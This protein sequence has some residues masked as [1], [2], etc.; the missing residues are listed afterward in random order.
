MKTKPFIFSKFDN[1]IRVELTVLFIFIMLVSSLTISVLSYYT[2]KAELDRSGEII[3]KNGVKMVKEAIHLKVNAV[4]LGIQDIDTAQ[5]EIK[6]L[7][8]GPKNSDGTRPINRN[9][10][11]GENGYFF[12]L[13]KYADEIAHPSIEG[14][15]TWLT[16]D[17][18]GKDFYV[19]QD[20]IKKAQNGGGFT[21]YSW[22]WPYSDRIAPKV[23]Y[24]EID[25]NWD[26]IIVSSIYLEDYN[27]GAKRIFL[28][29]IYTIFAILVIG[30]ALLIWIDGHIASPIKKM[31]KA[32]KHFDINNLRFT[33]IDV[34][35]RNEIGLLATSFNQMAENLIAENA[36]LVNAE[37]KLMQL[38]LE[39]EFRVK[40]RTEELIEANRSLNES[41]QM[42][43]MAQLVFGIAHEINT[44]LGNA[45]TLGSYIQTSMD[46][47]Q[48]NTLDNNLSHDE[49]LNNVSS[50]VESTQLMNKCLF[51]T[52]KLIETFKQVSPSFES[53]KQIRFNLKEL[54]ESVT[55]HLDN[56]LKKG[57][58][59]VIVNCPNT[60]VIENYQEDLFNVFGHLFM[61][62]I[63]HGF[64]NRDAGTIEIN[65]E[66]HS[67]QCLISYKDNGLGIDTSIL[68]RIFEPFFTTDRFSG[69]IGLGL[70]IV[71]NLVTQ[72]LGGQIQ[73]ENDESASGTIVRIELPLSSVRMEAEEN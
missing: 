17:M 63:L 10:D 9:V 32:I 65:V 67:K 4:N 15:N 55:I 68:N 46:D 51:T 50:I 14:Q 12:I 53:R 56:E 62:S 39:L 23:S 48:S 61:N 3:L 16:K 31:V 19:A 41:K 36:K 40:L 49:L 13:N 37:Q 25:P 22:K 2:A 20:I 7:I 72:K 64:K 58:H 18:S 27:K 1:S 73:V 21:Y 47:L 26:W 42:A 66:A 69:S 52:S 8:L 33:P 43:A 5:E 11:L 28:V 35:N 71:F 70:F 29:L 57:Q 44:P 60:L 54:L 30:F 38:N 59:K 24:S 34:R 6:Q 45:I